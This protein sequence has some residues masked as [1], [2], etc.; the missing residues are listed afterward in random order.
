MRIAKKLF[1]HIC[2]LSLLAVVVACAFLAYQTFWLVDDLERQFQ[3][4]PA[5]VVVAHER[6]KVFMFLAAGV[7]VLDVFLFLALSYYL[8]QSVISPLGPIL[9]LSRRL[10]LGDFTMTLRTK[11]KD[12]LGE[13]VRALGHMKDRLQHSIV[14]LRNSY[15]R[16]K[17]ARGEAEK[18]NGM[19]TEFLHNISHELRSPLNSIVEHSNVVLEQITHGRYDESLEQVMMSIR[20]S[21]DD[22]QGIISTMGELSRLEKNGVEV[23]KKEF[24]TTA[25]M[26]E[27]VDAHQQS[28]AAK[29]IAFKHVYSGNFP[30]E[31]KTDRG[32]LF[33]VLSNILAYCVQ[34]SNRETELVFTFEASRHEIVFGVRASTSGP[35]DTLCALFSGNESKDLDLTPYLTNA[36][37]LGLVSAVSNAQLLSGRL[38]VEV[39][40]Q[41]T[42]FRLSLPKTE[43]VAVGTETSSAHTA[44]NIRIP[45]QKPPKQFRIPT[46]RPPTQ[47]GS[48]QIRVLVFDED[49]KNLH[50]IERIL[51][52]SGMGC[53][54]THSP[55]GC[56]KVV[57]SGA[58]D[59]L[60]V[61]A[62]GPS[63]KGYELLSALRADHRY[64]VLP[65]IVMSNSFTQ[66]Q[67]EDF[68]KMGVQEFLMK[69]I[70]TRDL[71][72]AISSQA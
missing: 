48:R 52:E 12:E 58:V 21:A 16:E 36:R 49:K 68:L 23:K 15:E 7:V 6:V 33:H 42:Q 63:T 43:C 37:L 41:I 2:L 20:E 60:L 24:E 35:S 44:S 55:E 70:Q 30:R 47:S 46:Q 31:L 45:V 67:R 72:Q 22:L 56:F 54:A 62:G 10:A 9:D 26:K 50:Q 29:Q 1:I 11:S 14:K 19:K 61:E 64:D 18:A 27:L 40:G 17:K 5:Q 4:T 32:I 8:I 57:A 13:L 25:F 3:L 65:V 51:G 69:P 38:E 34:S 71:L 39:E 66:D 53:S 28:I 59:L